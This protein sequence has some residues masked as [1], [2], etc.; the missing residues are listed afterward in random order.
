[1]SNAL[2]SIV[3]RLIGQL[4]DNLSYLT[5]DDLIAAGWP[6]FL[7]ARINVELEKNLA[8]SVDL[9]ESDWANMH[10]EAVQDAWLQFLGAIRAETRL[11]IS[12]VRPVLE[13]SIEDV[14]ELLSQPLTFL[15]DYLYGSLIS[16]SRDHLAS[17][18]SKTGVYPQ[19]TQA[20]VRYLDRKHL[21]SLSKVDAAR[22]LRA[23]DAKL[24]DHFTALNWGQVLAPLFELMP[25]GVEPDLL[26]AYFHER[27]ML[28]EARAFSTYD[29]MV[30]KSKLIELLS[31]PFEDVA[32]EEP[33]AE[34]PVAAPV[35]VAPVIIQP[36]P[37]PEPEPDPIEEV[38][39][40][41]EI[42]P[43]PTTAIP[44]WQ[45]F[46]PQEEDEVTKVDE[47]TKEDNDVPILGMYSQDPSED[48]RAS[49]IL[50]LMSDMEEE[51]IERIFGG[52]ENAFSAAIADIAR[53]DTYAEAGR[54]IKKEIFDRNR[55]DLFSDDAVLFL[56]RVQTYFVETT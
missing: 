6:D 26:S 41:A 8:E 15:P 16:L 10:A 34:V 14:V 27:G 35:I 51:F 31:Q 21:D 45:R 12:Y 43:E 42:D 28:P 2:Q 46:M 3:D 53:Y 11:P 56:D 49:R 32:D 54:Y 17:R 24:S 22:I 48:P 44:I 52:D 50:V 13:T 20:L 47:V 39:T 18:V 29:H 7:V 33:V 37:E 5:P 38:V 55:I 30:D 4:P 19:L 40:P 36:E 23:V 25:D 1:M 9:P